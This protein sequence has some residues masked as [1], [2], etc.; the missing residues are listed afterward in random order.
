MHS[1]QII[2]YALYPLRREPLTLVLLFG[3]ILAFLLAGS[4]VDIRHGVLVIPLV[5]VI[6]SWF[7]KYAFVLMDHIVEGRP[8]LPVLSPEMANPLGEKRPLLYLLFI[9]V[10]YAATAFLELYLGQVWVAIVRLIG[11]SVLPAV[12]ATHAVTGKFFEALRPSLF[13]AMIWR[14]GTDYLWVLL[15]VTACWSAGWLLVVNGGQISFALRLILLM[16]LWLA[17]FSVLGG[18][19]F[20][21]RDELGYDPE[22]S[23]EREAER[24]DSERDR[25]RN[26]FIGL[27]FAEYRSGAFINAW[28]SIHHYARQQSKPLDQYLWIYERVAHWPNARLANRVAQ[29]MVPLLLAAQR[30]SEA[31]SIAKSRLQT[32]GEFRPLFAADLIRLVHLARDGGDKPLAKSL[33]KDFDRWFPNDPARAVVATIESSLL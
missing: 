14:M 25:V 23:P 30:N 17:Q 24:A 8:G 11:L 32:D 19:I 26:Q 10:I 12:I 5:A 28:N 21:R 6:S 13:N 20:E 22:H 1:G 2:K 29:E 33:L 7:F 16:L 18:A 27:V 31:L 15:L 4:T 3:G 9:V